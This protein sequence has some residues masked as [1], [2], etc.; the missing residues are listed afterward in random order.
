MNPARVLILLVALSACP[1]PAKPG[2]PPVWLACSV[3]GLAWRKEKR[4]TGR[5]SSSS[6]AASLLAE[7][8]ARPAPQGHE[9]GCRFYRMEVG[10]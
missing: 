5:L 1:E 6:V 10:P 4:L 2:P 9:G 8:R 3:D 7:A